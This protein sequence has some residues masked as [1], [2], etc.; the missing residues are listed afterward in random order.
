MVDLLTG[1]LYVNVHTATNTG[2]EIRGQIGGP[3]LFEANLTGAAETPP[4]NTNSSGRAV[5]ALSA[6]ATSLSYRVQVNDIQGITAAHIHRGAAGVAGPALF[7]LFNSGSGG[8]FDPTHPVSGTVSVST[9]QV[10]RMIGG[11]YYINAHTPM[12]PAGAIRGQI[13]AMTAPAH[14]MAPLTGA[15]EVPAVSSNALGLARLTLHD[16]LGTLHY[17]VAVTDITGVT[18]SHIHLA[19][20]GQNGGVVFALYN[21]SSGNPFDAANPIAGAVVPTAKDWVDLLTGYHYVNIHTSTHAGGEIRGQ[22]GGPQLFRAILAGSNEVPPVTTDATGLGVMALSANAFAIDFR[23]T[24]ADITGITAAHIHQGAAGTNGGVVAPLYVGIGDFDPANPVSGAAP[25]STAQVF[26]L[27]G[28][29]YY[30]NVH[31]AANPGG[32]IRGQIES[33]QPGTHYVAS[34]TGDQEVPPVTTTANGHGFFHLDSSM[35][36][37]HYSI[38]VTDV[39]SGNRISYPSWPERRQRWGCLCPLQRFQWRYTG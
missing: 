27:L 25:V 20:I 23:V 39:V 24:V 32:E 13:R 12:Y 16:G 38:S 33:Y 3:R 15:A 9:D 5:L 35:G 14:L 17:S 31:T 4:H 8:T 7:T 1:H 19:P 10:M 26:E 22:I 36:L 21:S 11:D 29:D 18:A 30:V 37:L 34:L 6:D 2:G 28:G